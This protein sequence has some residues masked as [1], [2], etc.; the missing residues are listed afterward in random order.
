MVATSGRGTWMRYRLVAVSGCDA[1]RGMNTGAGASVA[2]IRDEWEST[3]SKWRNRRIELNQLF[4][5]GHSDQHGVAQGSSGAALLSD[6]SALEQRCETSLINALEAPMTSTHPH[7]GTPAATVMLRIPEVADELGVSPA[8]VE[9]ELSRRALRHVRLGRLV[10]I[11]RA[12]LD[13]YV[14]DHVVAMDGE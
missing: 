9:R 11:R 3:R 5:C 10:R 7:T 6:G 13:A 14:A 8:F 2:G 4:R 1:H 12:D